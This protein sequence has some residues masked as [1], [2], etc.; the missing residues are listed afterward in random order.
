MTSPFIRLPIDRGFELPTNTIG[1][2]ERE[3]RRCVPESPMPASREAINTCV[4]VC[5][6]R[7]THFFIPH[8]TVSFS[9]IVCYY[10]GSLPAARSF[11]APDEPL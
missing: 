10:I 11:L 1:S 7:D 6:H 4:Y 2:A 3:A 5:E 8:S 9:T